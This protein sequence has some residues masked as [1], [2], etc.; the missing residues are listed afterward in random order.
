MQTAQGANPLSTGL[1]LS[2]RQ[3]LTLRSVR[4]LL[5]EI[6]PWLRALLERLLSSLFLGSSL[7]GLRLFR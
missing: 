2:W 3:V 7:L 1:L 5:I 6:L 4:S